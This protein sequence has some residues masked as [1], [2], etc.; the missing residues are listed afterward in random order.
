MYKLFTL[1]ITSLVCLFLASSPSTALIELTAPNIGAGTNELPCDPFETKSVSG[2]LPLLLPDSIF[3][4]LSNLIIAWNSIQKA[5][6]NFLL[7]VFYMSN[8]F[9]SELFPQT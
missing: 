9:Q 2:A 6:M 3:L 7:A 4:T 5:D 1:M 8:Y